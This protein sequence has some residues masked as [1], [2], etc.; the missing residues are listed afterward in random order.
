[1]T[2]AERVVDLYR[3]YAGVW[4]AARSAEF[5]ER[6]WIEWSATM[7]CLVHR[8]CSR[9]ALPSEK[10]SARFE[11]SPFTM[12]ASVRMNTACCLARIISLS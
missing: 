3:R 12:Q 4:V 6:S 10:P 1:M 9:A 8:C 2:A 7:P 5:R 11:G